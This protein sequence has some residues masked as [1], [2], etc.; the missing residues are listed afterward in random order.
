MVITRPFWTFMRVLK[1]LKNGS[2]WLTQK[3]RKMHKEKNSFLENCLFTSSR[4]LKLDEI[5]KLFGAKKVEKLGH[6]D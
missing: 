4:E 2:C 3:K 5:K 6:L 1:S